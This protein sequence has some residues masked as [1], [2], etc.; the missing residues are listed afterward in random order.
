MDTYLLATKLQ[1]P[2]PPHHA[3][4]R[5]RLT[6][7]L[8]QGISRYKLALI[9][10]PAGYGK[11]ALLAQWAHTS[12]LPVVW[13][14]LGEEDNDFGR[15]LQYLLAGWAQ[16]QPDIREGPLGLLSGAMMPDHETVLAAFINAI[17]STSGHLLFILDDYHLIEDPSIHQS[18][19]FL[20]DHLPPTAHFV[21][22]SRADP[23]LPLARYRARHELMEL[24]VDEI[25][26]S[27]EETADFLNQLMRLDLT[28]DELGALHAQLEGWIAGLQLVAL[29]RQRQIAITNKQVVTGR[30]RFIAD[31]LSENVL[32]RLPDATRQFLLQTSILD[33]L[34]DSLCEAVTR[35]KDCQAIL[36]TLERENLF[37]VA[38]D[39]QREWFRYHRLFAGFL[40]EQLK[41]RFPDEILQ[42]HRRAAKWYLAHELPEPAIH[43]AIASE[44][45]DLVV[46]L[47]DRYFILKV[48]SGEISVARRWLEALPAEW[49]ANQPRLSIFQAC[50]LFFTGQIDVCARYLD[51]IERQVV[52]AGS[53]SAHW[54]LARVTA[55]RCFLACY[56]NDFAPAVEAARQALQELPE[57]DQDLR[58]GIYVSLGDIHRHHGLWQE[59]E[60]YYLKALDKSLEFPETA[61][62]RVQSVEAFGALAD[63]ELRQGHLKAAATHWRRALAAIGGEGWGKFPLPLIGWVYIRLGEILYEWNAFAESEDYLMRGLERVELGGDTRGMIAGYLLAC[64]LRLAAG[65]ITAAGEN[66]ERARPL[67]ENASFPDWAANVGRLR[68]EFLLAQHRRA[69]AVAWANEMM[70]SDTLE[71]GKESEAARLA[72]AHA[73]TITGEDTSLAHALRLLEHILPVAQAEGRMGVCIEVMALQSLA[74]WRLG[75]SARALTSLEH[76]LRIAEPEGYIRL[77]ADYGLP[78]ARLLQEARVRGVMPDYVERLLAALGGDRSIPATPAG[79][80]PEPLSQREL[81]VLRLVAAGLTNREI[82]ESLVISPETVK[83]H[84]GSIFGKLGVGNRTEAST[85]ARELDLL[86]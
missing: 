13:L 84:T 5:A 31:Y 46:E 25:R 2:P 24:R 58:Q 67:V 47:F 38:L 27:L 86:G 70:R 71:G 20:L 51:N 37:L 42:F 11:T 49:R 22:A 56:K 54:H 32:A 12:H 63:L 35:E 34:C 29:T 52:E 55:I 75:E 80:L 45:F 7:V 53:G 73:L 74:R 36:E 16:V 1:I 30:H 4:Q 18:L 40:Q 77:F 28:R 78:M 19:A 21:L 10:A 76:A 15:F 44:D 64:R 59:A 43:H 79:T 17:A 57:V 69:A 14:S 62:Y 66:L 72:L 68:L 48:L 41:R 39:D 8:E 33:G 83:K 60:A 65:D 9:A 23:P 6:A 50:F 61:S 3:I 81:E 82:A 26:F 85:R